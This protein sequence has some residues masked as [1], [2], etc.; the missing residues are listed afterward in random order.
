MY[1]S[2]ALD[3][4]GGEGPVLSLRLVRSARGRALRSL[5]LPLAALALR[6]Q[7]LSA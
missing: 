6:F 3:L 4:K 1:G 2:D 7:N 5:L